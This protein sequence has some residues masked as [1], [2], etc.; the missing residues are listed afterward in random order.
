MQ[1]L[2]QFHGLK[3]IKA[4]VFDV[5][6]VWTDGRL[7]LGSQGESFRLFHIHDGY[8]IK[9]LIQGGWK[10]AIISGSKSQDIQLRASNLG[11]QDI[12]LGVE[13]KWPVFE[14]LVKKWGLDYSKQLA[15]AGDDVLDLP[16][17]KKVAFPIVVPNAHIDVLKN[18]EFYCT[19]LG[20]GYGAVREIADLFI[21]E[22]K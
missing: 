22:S 12:F 5:D 10:I 1:Q 15:Y 6:G 2:A 20:G 9:M 8:G 16:I 13:D 21:R 4:L 19:Q 17:L 18:S 3:Q 7:W 14:S 11:I